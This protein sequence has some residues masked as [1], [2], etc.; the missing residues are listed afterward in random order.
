MKVLH[1]DVLS[2][3]GKVAVVN[4]GRIFLVFYTIYKVG[5]KMVSNR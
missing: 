5:M 1:D 3:T 2:D 4:L